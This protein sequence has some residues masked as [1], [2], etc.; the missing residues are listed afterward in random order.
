MFMTFLSLSRGVMK[1]E[2]VSVEH[3]S[4][5][6]LPRIMQCVKVDVVLHMTLNLISSEQ[7]R[8]L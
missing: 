1:R 5:V 8:Q 6:E 4:R 3:T 2:G 7:S